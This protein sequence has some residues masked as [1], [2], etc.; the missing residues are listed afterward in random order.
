MKSKISLKM[1]LIKSSAWSYC[2]E[3]IYAICGVNDTGLFQDSP[4]PSYVANLELDKVKGILKENKIKFRSITVP[5]SNIFRVAKYIVVSEEDRY[6]AI[7]LIDYLIF[8]TRLLYMCRSSHFENGL[9]EF[10]W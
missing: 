7:G 6:K 10:D 3:P 8:E 2:R 1:R 5:T 9:D 4:C